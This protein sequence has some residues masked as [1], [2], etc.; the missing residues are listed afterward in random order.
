MAVFYTARHRAATAYVGTGSNQGESAALL[1]QA[2]KQVAALPG[3]HLLAISSMFYTE[4][5]DEPDQPWFFN[6]VVSLATGLTPLEL[7]HRL[8]HIEK[9]LGRLRAG[10]GIDR[11]GPRPIDLDILLYGELRLREPELILPHPRLTRRAFALIP[12][13]EI[14]PG[15]TLPDGSRAEDMLSR[16]EYRLEGDKIMQ[17]G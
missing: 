6:Q 4:P 16:L 17:K 13:L 2:V 9:D 10:A 3:T 8:Q 12:L 5:Q 7:L 1:A 15:L 11:F 14:A